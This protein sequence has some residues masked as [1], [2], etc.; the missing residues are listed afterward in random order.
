MK[1]L[2]SFFTAVAA[3]QEST[4][5]SCLIQKSNRATSFNQHHRALVWEDKIESNSNQHR[6]WRLH[7]IS[8]VSVVNQSKTLLDQFIDAQTSS[9]AACS[10][11]LLESKRALD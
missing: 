8:L 1:L 10:S 5:G 11:R 4:N 3:E 7:H 9:K 6:Q 2:I